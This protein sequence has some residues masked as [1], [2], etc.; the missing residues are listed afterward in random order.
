MKNKWWIYQVFLWTFVLSI[1]FGYVTNLI[2]FSSNTIVT[3]II[4][5]LVIFVGIL[6]DMIGTSSLTSSEAIF[7]AMASKKIKGAKTAVKLIK[8]NVKVSSVC[9]D[10]IGDICGI[11]SGGLGAVLAI[12]ISEQ[13]NVDVAI[14]T[15]LVAAFISS[16]T[17]G[18]KAI[19]K[20]IAYKNADKILSRCSKIICLFKKEK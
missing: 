19:C 3:F 20:S 1:I 14:V 7:H 4:I 16:L 15:M 11:V 9:N 18:G 13:F 6:F 8:N 10:I 17:V 12:S 2:S 5:L